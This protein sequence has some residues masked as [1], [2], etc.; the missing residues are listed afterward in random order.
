MLALTYGADEF[1]IAAPS[2]PRCATSMWKRQREGIVRPSVKDATRAVC[3]PSG[4]R[5]MKSAQG[6]RAKLPSSWDR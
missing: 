3:R 5:L 1:E 6:R 2:L 4:D